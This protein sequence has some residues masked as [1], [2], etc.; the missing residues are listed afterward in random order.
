M[1]RKTGPTPRT[2][3]TVQGRSGGICERCGWAEGQQIHHRRPRGMGGT[4]DADVNGAG[5]LLHVCYPCHR[6]IE[7]NREESLRLGYL[8]SRLTASKSWQVP[9]FYRGTWKLINDF[10]EAEK[11]PAPN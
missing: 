4:R 6:W 11:V 7:E 3:T 10:G 8:I 9:V 2:V 5:N 1:A